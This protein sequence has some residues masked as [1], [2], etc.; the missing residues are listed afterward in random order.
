MEMAYEQSRETTNLRLGIRGETLAYLGLLVLALVLR[1]VSLGDVPLDDRSAAEA[2]AALQD[3]RGN[4]QVVS[5][6][7]LMT[8]AN[9]VAFFIAAPSHTNARIPTALVGTLLVLGPLLWRQWMGKT[10]AL[11]MAVLLAISPV[12]LTASRMMG[13]VTWTMALVFLLVWAVQRYIETGRKSYA[14][15]AVTFFVML[16]VLSE[17]TG[18]ITLLGLAIGL[19][20]ALQRAHPPVKIGSILQNWPW[21]EGLMVA[22]GILMVVGTSFMMVPSGLTAIGSTLYWLVQGMFDRPDGTPFAYAFWVAM[23]Y[24]FGLVLFGLVALVVLQKN[25]FANVLAGWFAWSLVVSVLYANPTPD[26]AL[27]LTLPAAGLTA[28]LVAQM[29]RNP[30][31]GYWVVPTWGIVAHA[32]TMI[33]LLTALAINATNISS[34][35][36]SQAR[37]VYYHFLNNQD[38]I[39]L[40]T[41]AKIG[42]YNLQNPTS[43]FEFFVAEPTSLVVQIR[44]LDAGVNPILTA[45]TND[46]FQVGPYQYEGGR[47]GLVQQLDL[48]SAGTYYLKVT[49][50]GERQGQYMLLTYSDKVEE[51]GLVGNVLEGYQ[52]DIPEFRLLTRFVAAQA[53]SPL[54]LMVMVFLVMLMVIVYFLVGSLWGTRAAW[55]G[56][57]F[58]LLGY[59]T[60]YGL[61]LGWQASHTFAD[62]PRELWQQRPMLEKSERMVETLEQMSR[63]ENGTRDRLSI[64]VQGPDDGALAW[65]LRN[66]PN[67]TYVEGVGIETITAAVITPYGQEP[68]ALGADYVGQDFV[69]NTQWDLASLNWTDFGAWLFLR[70]TRFAPVPDQHYTLWVRSDVYGVQTVTTQ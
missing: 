47:R 45:Q 44:E 58:G 42:T 33:V 14:V 55:R 13:A 39:A 67:V 6:N 22:L 35:L 18:L 43:T 56:L 17:P 52:L 16:A 7:P 23:R 57:G 41:N 20:V 37:P 61:G 48:P 66:F 2:L 24:D 69:L 36:Q 12:A 46:G 31:T 60:I 65:L 40:T 25:F 64:T 50:T 62:D 68:V 51:Y 53:K 34:I 1:V 19:G 38:T 4:E 21:G 49:G 30:S 27:W 10:A 3:V 59:C 26:A 28:L 8:F 63:F 32:V 54:N 11:L 5:H 29:L 15:S 9:Q 70:E